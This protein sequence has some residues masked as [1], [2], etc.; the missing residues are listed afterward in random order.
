[1]WT[2]FDPSLPFTHAI[3]TQTGEYNR[4]IR[5]G[6]M[7]TCSTKSANTVTDCIPSKSKAKRTQD[8]LDGPK[9]K[10][11]DCSKYEAM[12]NTYTVVLEWLVALADSSKRT[13]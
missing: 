13:P 6:N 10:Q 3:Y 9:W 2:E 1:M 4:E 12:H 7:S 5:N 11:P 8:S